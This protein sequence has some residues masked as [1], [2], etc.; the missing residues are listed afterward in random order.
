M[1]RQL[2]YNGHLIILKIPCFIYP[3]TTKTSFF[4]DDDFPP[5]GF[6]SKQN[7]NSEVHG[8]MDKKNFF[9]VEYKTYNFYC[10]IHIGFDLSFF[11]R[12]A[13][14]CK[15]VSIHRTNEQL[16]STSLETLIV[17]SAVGVPLGFL[18]IFLLAGIGF[19]CAC[20]RHRR[21]MR[22]G[23]LINGVRMVPATA[24]VGKLLI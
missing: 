21:I 16:I 23:V 1:V 22:E 6:K 3:T 17:P 2:K 12:N 5:L 18:G 7:L 11:I 20:K 9:I 19:Y 8:R 24:N 14:S 13:Q 10:W 15:N 4:Q